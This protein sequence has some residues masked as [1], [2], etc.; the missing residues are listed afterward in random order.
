MGAERRRRACVL[1]AFCAA[2]IGAC[3]KPTYFSRDQLLDS[4]TCGSC[5]PNE[6][7]EWQQSMHAYA[8]DDPVFR[9]MN[10]RGQRA[11][12]GGLGDFCVKCHAP[13]AVHEAATTDGTNLDS[14]D[15]KLKGVTCYF[16]HDADAVNGTHNN[17]LHL[18]DDV[19]MRGEYPRPYP[20]CDPQCG[21]V[22]PPITANKAHPSLYSK[23]HDR[24]QLDSSSLC[25]SC[26]D[27][28]SP[29]GASIERTFQEW[30]S[31][32][33]AGSDN[34]NDGGTNC[35]GLPPFAGLTCSQCH[36]LQSGGAQ[37]IA[38]Y[39]GVPQRRVH[40]HAFPGV[41]AALSSPLTATQVQANNQFLNTTFNTFQ[42]AICVW[43][44]PGM[45]PPQAAIRIILDNVS[46]GHA[47]PSGSAQDRRLWTEV[48]A[49]KNGSVIYESGVVPD[50]GSPLD[51]PDGGPG[52]DGGTL[53][54]DPDRWLARDCMFNGSGAET[55]N[56]WEAASY[57]SNLFPV[58]PTVCQT[59]PRFYLSHVMQFFPRSGCSVP[60]GTPGGFQAC[61]GTFS[62]VPDRVTLRVRLQPIGSDVLD[63]LV[64]SGDLDPSLPASMPIYELG[65]QLEWTPQTAILVF[66]PPGLPGADSATCVTATNLN[67]AASTTVATNHRSCQP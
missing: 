20:V 48:V 1:A 53:S 56:V 4:A 24:D 18:A 42:S 37:P 11:T 54:G 5:H 40:D 19:T 13:M 14:V 25:G 46:A 59:D 17:P 35:P 67:L 3:G 51:V 10:A 64:T 27:I 49:Y 66:N 12:D 45:S 7:L 9:A 34:T 47:V 38:Q 33:F 6:Y 26:H 60:E 31:S 8:S 36:M 62:P 55:H 58:S 21:M 30:L 15:P 22:D 61:T 63:E 39:A 50:G 23:R 2:T 65:T 32:Q 28:V 52:P 44:I 29:A 57:E 16:C 41:D 43:E